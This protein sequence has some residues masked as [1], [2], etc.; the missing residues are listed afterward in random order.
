MLP[1]RVQSAPELAESVQFSRIHGN[2][3]MPKLTSKERKDLPAKDFAGPGRSFPI[4]DKSHAEDAVRMASRSYNAGNITRHEKHQIVAK[5][6][7]A[8]N[9]RLGFPRP[10]SRGK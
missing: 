1:P 2:N 6:Q 7:R 4:P 10:S 8:L 5:A 3:A 9:S